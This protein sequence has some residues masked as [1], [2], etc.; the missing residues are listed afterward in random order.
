MI[1]EARDLAALVALDKRL[2]LLRERQLEMVAQSQR[3]PADFWTAGQRE[4]AAFIRHRF[5]RQ[6]VR[7][8]LFGESERDKSDED[9]FA[10]RGQKLSEYGILLTHR[11]LV[12]TP[13]V[14]DR[15]WRDG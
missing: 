11:R 10:E 15:A 6:D 13:C 4:I 3:L 5:Y 9:A 8:L 12:D 1:R 2:S 7:I 14:G